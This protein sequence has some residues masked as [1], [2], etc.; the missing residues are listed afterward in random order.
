VPGAA[1]EACIAKA[2]QLPSHPD[3]AVESG[4]KVVSQMFEAFADADALN[5][6]TIALS[7]AGFH[8]RS[9]SPNDDDLAYAAGLPAA[10]RAGA[11]AV[12]AAALSSCEA[13]VAGTVGRADTRVQTN[14]LGGGRAT[15]DAK[16]GY[17]ISQTDGL[18][19]VLYGYS[20]I[21][22]DTSLANRTDVLRG[23][24][25]TKLFTFVFLCAFE[26]HASVHRL[27]IRGGERGS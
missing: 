13:L 19:V 7:A 8:W 5:T 2:K 1:L 20:Q 3:L 4:L 17:F 26:R 23:R 22:T 6:T 9:G 10:E 25:P 11:V 24:S 12:M 15:I 14:L 18:P 16:T 21:D 27:E